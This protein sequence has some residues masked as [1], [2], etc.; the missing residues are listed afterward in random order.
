MQNA[1][2]DGVFVRASS[3]DGERELQN[4]QSPRDSSQE[5]S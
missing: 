2:F 4:E 5:R 3:R 1:D